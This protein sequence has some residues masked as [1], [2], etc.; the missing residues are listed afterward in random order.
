MITCL[1][2]VRLDDRAL[3]TQAPRTLRRTLEHDWEHRMKLARR[4]GGPHM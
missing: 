4:P 1:S 2:E 3:V